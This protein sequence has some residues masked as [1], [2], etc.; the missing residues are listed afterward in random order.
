MSKYKVT[1]SLIHQLAPVAQ[2]PKQAAPCIMPEEKTF[3]SSEEAE[4]YKRDIESQ[5]SNYTCSI[6]EVALAEV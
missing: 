3:G 2:I 5:W 4:Q 1:P 6:E